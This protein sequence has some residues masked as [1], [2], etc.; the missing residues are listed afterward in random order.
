VPKS[1]KK[2]DLLDLGSDRSSF[3]AYDRSRGQVELKERFP[4]EGYLWNEDFHP[5]PISLRSWGPWTYAAIW[6]TMVAIVPTW[7]LAV[8]GPAFGLNWWQSVLEVFLGNAVVLIPMLIQSHG[9]ARYG[10]SEAQLSRTRWGIYGTQISSWVRA[11]VSMGWWG[12]ESYIITEAAVA[13]YVVASGRT[14]LLTSG[15]QTYSLSVMF[16]RIFWVT[17]AAVIATQLLLFYVSPPRKGQPPLKW[18]GA[19]AAPVVL[20]GFLTLFLSVMLGTGWRFAPLNP[21]SLPASSFGFWLGAIAF[22]NANVAFW[23]TMV[24]S[25]PDF[26]RFAKS[27]KAHVWGQLPMPFMMAGIGALGVITYGG[28]KLLGLNGGRG[29]A[30]P[31]LLAAVYLPSWLSYFVLFSFMLA[32]YAVNVYANSVAP[33]YDIANTYSKHLSWFRGIVI[34]VVISALLGAWTFYSRGAYSYIYDWLLAYGGVL[35]AV[36]GV[37]VFDYAVIRRF[38]FEA[39]DAYLS[40]GRFRY[41]HGVNPAAVLAFV[42]AVLLTYLSPL[43]LVVNPVTQMLYANSWI[44]AFLVSGLIYLPLMKFWVIPRYQPFLKGGLLSGYASDDVQK[45]FREEGRSQGLG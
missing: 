34:G 40:R 7:M 23:A 41:L 42:G 17:F 13:A 45:V 11:V 44:T 37:T 18:L 1:G 15:V 12:I 20:A 2:E 3:I 5:T 27:Q 35:G 26:T 10:M 9:G 32:T 33:G 28:T 29:I 16:P 25:M 24:R 21:T 31:V 8:A 19:F 14:S 30:D 39:V 43:G 38:K 36:A 6:F 4:E 22:L